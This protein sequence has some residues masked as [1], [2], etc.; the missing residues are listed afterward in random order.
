MTPSRPR[1]PL[2]ILPGALGCFDGSDVAAKA[3]AASREVATIPYGRD[4]RL[5]GLFGKC[6]AAA[7]D[8]GAPAVDL[9]G[10]SYGG[11][12]AQCFAR[13]A[14][15]RVRR[16]ILSHSFTLEAR[17]AWRFRLS[18]LVLD[19]LPRPIARALLVKRAAQALRPLRK[20][21]PDLHANLLGLL[22]ERLR[23]GGL[24][25]IVSAQQR[26]MWESL[27]PPMSTTPPLPPD[28]P[29]LILESDDDRLIGAAARAALRA[30][31]PNAKVHRF[32]GTGHVSALAA[33]DEY[34]DVVGRFLD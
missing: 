13:H 17:D 2:V 20:A 27:Q 24:F 23:S 29:V 6:L 5:A 12:I 10:Q 33:P 32:R 3:L 21:A 25:E 7:Q 28:I 18:G 14:P 31:F 30:R 26:C 34:V 16:L 15:V 4:D 19:T 22:A 11:W 9:L 8:P 1:T